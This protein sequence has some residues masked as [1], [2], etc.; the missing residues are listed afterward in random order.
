VAERSK[1]LVLGTSPKGRGFESHRCHRIFALFCTLSSADPSSRAAQR[2]E[3]RAKS[4]GSCGSSR[5]A[6][7]PRVYAYIY[8]CV[9]DRRRDALIV[10]LDHNPITLSTT[11]LMSPA[12]RLRPSWSSS[13]C[14]A[15][16]AC[17]GLSAGADPPGVR[18]Y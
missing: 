10:V 13:V 9:S 16:D 17:G 18:L 1:A 12:P 5:S 7:Q 8:T 14:V 4:R 6:S 2:E 11:V 15:K 3:G